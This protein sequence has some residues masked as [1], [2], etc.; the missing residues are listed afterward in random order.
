MAGGPARPGPEASSSRRPWPTTTTFAGQ[1]GPDWPSARSGAGPT[2]GWATSCSSSAAATRPRGPT[3]GP[4]RLLDAVAADFPGEPEPRHHL[5][6]ARASLG[7]LLSDRGDFAGADAALRARPGR[8]RTRSSPPAR[9]P[10][11]TGSTWPG[12]QGPGRGPPQAGR[13]LRGRAC[14]SRRPARSS[15]PA[16][17][18]GDFLPPA[19]SRPTPATASA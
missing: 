17:F 2:S 13:E 4:A 18:K 7:V 19:R 8:S 3:A 5:A 1:D 15:T 9:P 10:R 12:R 6:N 16:D 11:G 14:S